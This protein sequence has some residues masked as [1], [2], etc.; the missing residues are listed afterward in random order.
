MKKKM[1]RSM[2]KMVAVSLMTGVIALGITACGNKESDK[3]AETTTE[4]A[5][6]VEETTTEE[7]TT[8]E[9]TTEATTE[10]V[11]TED[12]VAMEYEQTYKPEAGFMNK[13]EDISYGEK[14]AI[15]YYSNTTGKD[16][17]A[18]VILPEGYDSANKYPVVYML[19]GIGGTEGEWFQGKPQEIIGNLIASGEVEPFIAVMP[20][21]RARAN[22][23]DISDMYQPT[24]FQ[25]FDNFINDLRDDLMPYINENYSVY[26]DREHTAICG[27]SMGG[28][29]SLSI[30]FQMLDTFGYIGAF[31]PAPTL[32]TSLLTLE[33]SEYTP[34]L[35][36]V[37]NG[38][39]DGVVAN[40]PTDYHNVMVKNNVE[41][42][43]YQV[44]GGD[45]N[46]TVWNDGLYN[47]V[48][49]LFKEQ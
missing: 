40:V 34:E 8:E 10:K 49:R 12:T 37:C 36:L 6:T 26:G 45:H 47:F 35:V 41:H 33:G 7:T 48:K 42:I 18:Y 4:N 13:K 21:V 19:H 27:L 31:S 9:T 14:V 25:A 5:T 39:A 3:E 15:T 46:F 11:T 43:W 32:D 28:M 17:K 30:G 22:D 38:T 44:P 2:R 16:R 20:N 29:E 24:N 23:T 1:S